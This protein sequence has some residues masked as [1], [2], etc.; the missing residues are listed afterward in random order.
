MQ[1]QEVNYAMQAVSSRGNR[2]QLSHG[3]C[4][5]LL[6]WLKSFLSNRSQYVVVDNQKS[7]SIEVLSG[8]PQ[9]TV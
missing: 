2:S 8:V 9:G 7:H 3:I 1:D 6:F 4:D 5:T